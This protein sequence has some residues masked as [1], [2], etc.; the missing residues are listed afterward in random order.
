MTTPRDPDEILAAWL[1]DGPTRLPDQTR[2]A[3][4]VSLPMTRQRRYA[5][6]VP[7][8]FATM[9]STIKFAFGAV[10]VVA[11]VLGGALLLGQGGSG[12]SVGGVG[13]APTLSLVPSPT[14][15]AIP[16]P[17]PTP[18]PSPGSISFGESGAPLTAGT[19]TGFDPFPIKMSI[20]VPDGWSGNVGGPYAVFLGDD[21]G[22]GSIGVTIFND[23]YADPCDSGKGL[24]S[25]RPGPAVDDL[26]AALAKMP[27]VK[28]T[29]PVTDTIGGQAAKQLT[30]TAPAPTA[31][32][33]VGP[34][35]G[36]FTTWQ[37][38]LGAVGGM[39]PG[40]QDRVWVLSVDGTRIVIDAVEPVVQDAAL[41]A[42]IQ[43]ILDSIQIHPKGS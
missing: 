26:V 33:T 6:G 41:H 31:T 43:S 20:T 38:P 30:L 40:Q 16:T 12:G 34:T 21:S 11:L 14:P 13:G 18:S 8:R 32:C 23:V 37:L 3:I 27:N 36:I 15:T 29:K 39:A 24:V 5:L 9:S 28:P 4:A 2:R 10:G 42:Q 35:D 19:Y 25:P 17:S 1:D 7:R 22:R